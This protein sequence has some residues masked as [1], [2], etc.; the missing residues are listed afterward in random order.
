MSI[1]LGSTNVKPQGISKV[2]LGSDLVYQAQITNQELWFYNM[3]SVMTYNTAT[4]KAFRKLIEA[5]NFQSTLKAYI[6]FN[7]F[8]NMIVRS[9]RDGS[10][11]WYVDF[12]FYNGTPTIYANGTAIQFS[13]TLTGTRVRFDITNENGGSIYDIT[14]TIS[15]VS[16]Q[17]IWGYNMP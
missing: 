13:S 10:V 12:I 2:Y 7:Q 8:E 14:G 1:K 17:Q 9:Y 4:E 15:N 3:I 5:P 11:T 6:P 16:S